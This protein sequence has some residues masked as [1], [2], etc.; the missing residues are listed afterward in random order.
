MMKKNWIYI[1][2]RFGFYLLLVVIAIYA[3][4]P[5]YW[6]LNTS[7]K[8]EEELY[9]RAT[10]FPKDPT[11]ENY[12]YVLKDERFLT[13]LRNSAFVSSF[14]TIFSLLVG[15]FAA[16]ALGRLKFRGRTFILYIILSMTM[17]P[18]ISV[19]SGLYTIIKSAGLFGTPYALILTY[20]IFTLPFTVWVLTAFFRGLPTEIEQAAI[21]DGASY[22]QIFWRILLPLT[23]PALVTTGLISFVRSWN[24][25][26]FALNFTLTNPAAQTVT[27]TVAKFTGA[28]SFQEPIREIMAAAMFVTIPL[29]VL[30]L[31]FQKR[32]VAGLTAGAVKG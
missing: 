3:L 2:Q 4:F 21:V 15:S 8:T 31:V 28:E 17:F 12:E 9:Q 18:A 16:Y 13:S 22:L 25:Y 24:E 1:L 14:T 10:L 30:V 6:A 20:P 19:L 27:V 7:L 23:A 26:L 5:F 32:I 29:V 11:L